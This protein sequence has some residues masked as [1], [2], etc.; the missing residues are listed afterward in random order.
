MTN[1]LGVVFLSPV[2]GWFLDHFGNPRTVAGMVVHSSEAYFKLFCCLFVLVLLGAI[3]VHFI[4]ETRG[5]F[6]RED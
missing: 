4:P 5:K 1:Y 2:V 3:L 6:Q